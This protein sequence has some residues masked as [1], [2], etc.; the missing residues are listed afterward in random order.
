M[1]WTL[2]YIVAA[3][4]ILPAF[5][6]GGISQIAATG[7]FDRYSQF[8]AQSGITAHELARKLLDNAGLTNVKVVRIDGHLSDCYD[9][10]QKVVKL[11]T[12]TYDSSSISAL[13]VCAHEVGHAIQDA[14]GT[15]LFRI[16]TAI[17]PVVNFLS[18]LYLPLV[19]A[20]SIFGFVLYIT[21]FGYY[22]V[23]AA[24]IMYGAN[25]IFYFV[26]LPLEH[27]AS[28]RAIEL[29]RDTG[30]LNG[31]ELASAKNVLKAA[32]QTYIATLITSALYFLRFLSYA[33]IFVKG[34]D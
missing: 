18:K 24:V 32:I 2:V 17:V 7:T 29:L 23:W 4:C 13:G 9:P 33:M 21:P 8:L 19:L 30:T 20:G 12:A 10:R 14:K 31:S 6:Y 11:S 26:T 5:I 15:L 25:T 34:N 27:D 3:L 28:K 1:D 16:R 22:M